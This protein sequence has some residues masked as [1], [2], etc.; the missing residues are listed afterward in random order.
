MITSSRQPGLKIT[1]EPFASDQRP[2][3]EWIAS[4]VECPTNNKGQC[5][6]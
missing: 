3:R 4:V 2:F 5:S 1:S 6:L